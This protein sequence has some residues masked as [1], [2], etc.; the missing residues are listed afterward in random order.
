MTEDFVWWPRVV[1]VAAV[2]FLALRFTYE[3]YLQTVE[4]GIDAGT[5]AGEFCAAFLYVVIG[6][7]ATQVTFGYDR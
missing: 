5:G 4:F 1:T 7:I 3:G 6:V 2:W